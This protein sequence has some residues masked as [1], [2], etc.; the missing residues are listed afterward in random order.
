MNS[1]R[2]RKSDYMQIFIAFICGIIGLF[3]PLFMIV[4]VFLFVTDTSRKMD[5]QVKQ[6][7]KE[8]SE[9]QALLAKIYENNCEK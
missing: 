3:N 2:L 9:H 7:K 1:Y 5:K 4:S 6:L 8:E